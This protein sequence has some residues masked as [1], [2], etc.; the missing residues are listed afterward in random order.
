MTSAKR[1]QIS[2]ELAVIVDSLM[3]AVVEVPKLETE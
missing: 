3:E 2:A 1:F